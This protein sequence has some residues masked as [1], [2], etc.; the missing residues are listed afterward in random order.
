MKLLSI[1]ALNCVGR[2]DQIH[3][4]FLPLIN[5]GCSFHELSVKL[6]LEKHKS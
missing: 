3:A 2:N 4:M 6:F 1:T 5:G